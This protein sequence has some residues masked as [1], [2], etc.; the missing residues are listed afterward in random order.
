MFTG[1]GANLFDKY[2]YIV[3]VKHVK[4]DLETQH[5]HGR[6]LSTIL[7]SVIHAWTRYCPRQF[8]FITKIEYAHI[9]LRTSL[10]SSFLLVTSGLPC[11][12]VL[13]KQFIQPAVC[14]FLLRPWRWKQYV[15]PKRW[16]YIGLYG[17]SFQNTSLSVDHAATTSNPATCDDQQI[18]Y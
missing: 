6:I 13:H 5:P 3:R 15:L 11:R 17:V 1:K 7:L 8:N 4:N 18:Y 16:T 14:W 10:M 9:T 12:R 2:W